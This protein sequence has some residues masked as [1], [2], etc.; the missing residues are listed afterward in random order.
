MA[1]LLEGKPV[2]EKIK[3]ALRKRVF[4]LKIKP[5]LASIIVGDNPS[6]Q[7]YVNSQARA[8]QEVG[9]EYQLHKIPSSATESHLLDFIQ[10]LNLNKSINGI[11]VQSPLP[12]HISYRKAVSFIDINKD[13]EGMHP[14]NIGKILLG[15][16]GIIPCTASAVMELISVSGIGLYGK[17]VVIV[18]HSEIVGKPLALLLLRE[19]ATVTVC[20]IGTSESGRLK[21]HVNRAEVLV[22]SAGIPG[23]IK[24]AWIKEKAV[25]IDVGIS[26]VKDKIVG[27]VEFESADKRASYITPVPGGVG[28]LTVAMLMRNLIEASV[29]QQ[30]GIK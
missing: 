30:S 5:A 24:G 12:E 16:G 26:R 8:A 6:S 7:S 11:I 13:V 28:P 15:E 21:E 20:H 25:V 22:V 1:K 19:M 9:V 10:K 2:A 3:E 14:A 17:E 27:D 23:L 4:S 18:G 29:I